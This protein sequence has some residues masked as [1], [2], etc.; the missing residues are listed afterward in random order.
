MRL[1]GMKLKGVG[2]YKD[3]FSIDFAALSRSH[4]FLIEGRPAPAKPPSLMASPSRS[5]GRLRC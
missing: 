3:E 2:P 5:M 4:M 1:I